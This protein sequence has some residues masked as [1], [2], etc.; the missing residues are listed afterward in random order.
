[1]GRGDN[2]F[3]PKDYILVVDADRQ[4]VEYVPPAV[5]RRALRDGC[6]S[7]FRKQPF[8]IQL[9]PGVDRCPRTFAKARRARK[10][11][12]TMASNSIK[13]YTEYFKEER[14]VWVKATYPGQVSLQFQAG[15][16][17]DPIGV[18]VPFTGDPVR[19]TD[20]VPFEAIKRSTDLRKLCNPRRA[21]NGGLKPAALVLLTEEDV[22]AH[23]AKKAKRKGLFIKDAL[24]NVQ[25]DPDTGEPIPDIEA[26]SQPKIT[27]PAT[28]TPSSQIPQ[29]T[30][31]S[32]Q[33]MDAHSDVANVGKEGSIQM[34]E[35]IEP[36][37]LNLIHEINTAESEKDRPLA[38]DVLDHFEALFEQGALNE[39]TLNHILAMGH[40]K[41]VKTWASERLSELNAEA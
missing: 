28:T 11:G 8:S 7:V 24:G 36:S 17:S 1:M 31:K 34:A 38:D 41:T 6:V 14:D 39:E 23:Y 25:K 20:E 19:L 2:G 40:Y 32:E 9:P 15:P 26:A 4:F 18:V 16:G 35:A 12:I 21:N 30:T 29:G 13:N 5:A 37:V 3:D 27:E 33:A 22:Q 10:K